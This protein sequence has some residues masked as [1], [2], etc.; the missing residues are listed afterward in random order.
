MGDSNCEPVT[1][2]V[3]V[4]KT[5]SVGFTL[6]ELLVVIAIIA[7]LAAMLLPAL[8][9][10]KRKAQDTQCIGN[11]KQ[12]TV[13]AFMYENDYGPMDYASTT[14]WVAALV[15]YQGNNVHIAYC[16]LATTNNVPAL[17]IRQNTTFGGNAITP[18]GFDNGGTIRPINNGA[19]YTLNGWLYQ[20]EP[21]AVGYIN[22]QTSVGQKGLFNK[23]DNVKH[24]AQTPMF[25]DG[26]WP[27]FWPNSGTATAA[28]DTTGNPLNT[29]TGNN[30]GTVG[31]MIG[32]IL[33]ARHGYKYPGGAPT[34][35]VTAGTVLPGGVN[36]GMCDGH[37]EYSKLN[38]LWNYY[39]HALSVPQPMP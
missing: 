26:V 8:S 2:L 15:P 29:F 33:I 30:D 38:N 39:W 36:A 10:A 23:L 21:V 22:T 3:Q 17:T 27:D 35:N 37:V 25:T 6:I 14:L 11:V 31:Q 34:I 19:S 4:R 5:R 9:A 16:P 18:W 12:M 1:R 24:A 13:A 32:R 7:I 28:G 20:N